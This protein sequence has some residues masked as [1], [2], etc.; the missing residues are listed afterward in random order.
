MKNPMVSEN[1][2]DQNMQ[3]N[4]E[5]WSVNV[6]TKIIFLRRLGAWLG[7]VTLVVASGV[8]PYSLGSLVSQ[9]DNRVPINPVV[10]QA[11]EAIAQPLGLPARPARQLVT[12]LTNLLWS[13]ALFLPMGVIAWQLYLLGKTGQTTPKRWFELQ[14]V[15]TLGTPPGMGR[16][17]L[18][19]GLGKWGIPI[20]LA[21]LVWRVTGAFPA[22]PIFVG[23]IGVAIAGDAL[24]MRT[25][26][27]KRS[28]HDQIAHTFL[29]DLQS[30]RP[31]P[32]PFPHAAGMDEDSAIAAMI[33]NDQPENDF[34][35][36]QWMK[37]HP[38]LTVIIGSA[39]VLGA[40]LATFVGTQ[41]YVQ[42][43]ANYRE[44]KQLDNDLFLAL[45][46]K[47][48]PANPNV[49]E[50]RVAILAL[51]SAQDS[52]AIPLLTD[53]IAQEKDPALFDV[54][55]QAIVSSGPKSLPY[56]SRL[57]QALKS[58][59]ESLRFSQDDSRRKL[60]TQ[61]L[62]ASQRAIAKILSVYS[63]NLNS[64]DLSNTDLGLTRLKDE[65]AFSL[66]LE[67]TDLSGVKFNGAVLSQSSL[68]NSVFYGPGPDQRLGTFDDAIAS[69]NN[70]NLTESNLTATVMG[71]VTM[72]KANLFKA[73]LNNA[74]FSSGIF[75]GSNF[76]N[77]KLIGANFVGA[78]LENT[79]FTGA[80]LGSANF[81]EANLA[82]A[83]FTQVKAEGSQFNRA[84]LQQTN[85]QKANLSGADFSQANLSNADL[86]SAVLSSANLH[87]AKLKNANLRGANLGLADLQGADLTGAD[88]KGTK[89][90][91][92]RPSQTDQFVKGLPNTGESK[93]LQNVDFTYVKNLDKGQTS[94]IC[95]QGAIHP[96]CGQLSNK[97]KSSPSPAKK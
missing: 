56:L 77:S 21:Y 43:Q 85:W 2:N 7:E 49:Q 67:H 91:P 50:R 75:T 51:G 58:E 16:V 73:V 40:I 54:I 15:S 48:S 31:Y 65:T 36:W 88:M 97:A 70:A 37:Q 4:Q 74:N 20:S 42:N 72:Q 94:Y 76:S 71:P 78:N 18:R 32:N 10:A 5:D 87:R 69:F 66:V 39:S 23:L 22:L 33:L 52:R 8:I 57:N 80:D 90:A 81:S 38:G 34:D 30:G 93:R 28:G 29:L 68:Q 83:R 53:L 79:T 95:Q 82:N 47:L 35:L 41:I 62:Q 59:L 64:P 55:Q 63:G 84:N 60:V 27:W 45:V 6:S 12:P 24:I 46:T 92:S 26:R 25:N 13:G 1:L 14:V 11:S 9:G 89:I 3:L 17:L 96:Q 44:A 19:E 86:S 61:R